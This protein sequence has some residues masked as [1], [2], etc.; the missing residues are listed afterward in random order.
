[1]YDLAFLVNRG[2]L[3][4]PTGRLDVPEVHALLAMPTGLA[5]RVIPEVAA[6]LLARER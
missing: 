2:R 1:M 6:A 5:R 4:V 3:A